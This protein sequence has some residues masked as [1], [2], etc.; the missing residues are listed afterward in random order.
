MG[1]AGRS[2]IPLA[3]EVVFS[4]DA[5]DPPLSATL[6]FWLSP[7]T[8]PGWNG[9]FKNLS[10]SSSVPGEF[11]IPGVFVD[12]FELHISGVPPETYMKDVTYA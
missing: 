9:E 11:L 6:H 12:D 10:A 3:G 7:L 5:P 8:R 4:G 1:V 2:Q